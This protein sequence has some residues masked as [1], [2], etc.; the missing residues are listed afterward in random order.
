MHLLAW[1]DQKEKETVWGKKKSFSTTPQENTPQ[2]HETFLRLGARGLEKKKI[3]TDGL[4]DVP[5]GW[6]VH[7][8]MCSHA[9]VCDHVCT[10][11]C[12]YTHVHVRGCAQALS[13][14]HCLL[15]FQ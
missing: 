12:R 11:M 7:A 6:R 1:D 15:C 10:Y 8:S 4:E 13:I 14:L 2:S 5:N 9:Y 3:A